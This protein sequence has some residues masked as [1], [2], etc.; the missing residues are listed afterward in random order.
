MVRRNNSYKRFLLKLIG[1]AVLA[2]IFP[3]INQA[4]TNQN[5][6]ESPRTTRACEEWMRFVD[7]SLVKWNNSKETILI[8]IVRLG[9]S[10]SSRRLNQKRIKTLKQYITYRDKEA[11]FIIAEGERAESDTGGTIEMYV[12]G[13]LYD[14]LAVPSG[15]DI[16]L[17]NCNP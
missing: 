3:V 2:I 16:P 6:P 9:S 8:I 11:K 4:Q 13:K 14:S 10:E 12:E 17:K 1:S 15:S 5:L 7:E